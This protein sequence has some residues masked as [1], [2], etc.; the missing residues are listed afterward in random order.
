MP[1][2]DPAKKQTHDLR[3]RQRHAERI[4]HAFC[5]HAEHAARGKLWIVRETLRR[6]RQRE[7][8]VGIIQQRR[9]F[10]GSLGLEKRR[11]LRD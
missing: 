5:T 1:F 10:G 11:N 6:Q 2:R 9:P 7:T 4:G 3:L 8:A